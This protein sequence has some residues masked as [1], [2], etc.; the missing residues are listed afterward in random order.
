MAGPALQT[1]Q[2]KKTALYSIKIPDDDTDLHVQVYFT[3][4]FS[5]LVASKKVFNIIRD[6]EREL[7]SSDLEGTFE[8][9][10]MPEVQSIYLGS[11]GFWKSFVTDVNA[12]LG[13]VEKVLIQNLS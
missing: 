5:A 8:L 1:F 2:E 10:L 6:I 3:A 9:E 4:P 7:A 12:V 11:L 13:L